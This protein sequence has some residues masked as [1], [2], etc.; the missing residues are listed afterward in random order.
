MVFKTPIFCAFIMPI[1]KHCD[2][3]FWR[4][5]AKIIL[6]KLQIKNK[7]IWHLNTKKIGVLN[8]KFFMKLTPGHFFNGLVSSCWLSKFVPVLLR[9]C[10]QYSSNYHLF[11]LLWYLWFWNLNCLKEFL[12]GQVIVWFFIAAW[13]LISLDSL[14]WTLLMLWPWK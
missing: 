5:N 3:K 2:W 11:V 4:L 8:T 10:Q 1:I 14:L 12:P 9:Q 13:D 6:M 7:K